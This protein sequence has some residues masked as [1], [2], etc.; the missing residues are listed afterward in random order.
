MR[1]HI[2]FWFAA[3]FVLEVHAEQPGACLIREAREQI[4]VTVHYD[5]AYRRLSFPGGDVPT[6]RG[7]VRGSEHCEGCGRAAIAECP[8]CH[9]PRRVGTLHCGACGAT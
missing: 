4:G 8:T 6:D 5:P 3:L 9:G 7:R 1:S 2:A